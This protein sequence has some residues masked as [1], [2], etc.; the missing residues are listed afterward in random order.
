MA[1]SFMERRKM[2]VV[3]EQPVLEAWRPPARKETLTGAFFW[4]SAFCFVYCARPEDLIPGLSYIPLAKITGF[5]ALVALL[6]SLGKSK[7]GFRDL[8]KEAH[9]LL[10]MTAILY[11]SAVF[12]PVWRGGA[13]LRTLDF[14]KVYI[15]WILTFLAVNEFGR[16]RRLIFI[17]TAS[18]ALICV[19]SIAKGH[20]RPRLDGVLGGIYSN[21][22][23][24]AFAIV[25]SLPFCLAFL[26]A[27]K[28]IP[29]KAAWLFAILSMLVAVFLT[30]SRGGFITLVVAG[31]VCLWHFGVK[32]R[33]FYLVVAAGLLGSVLLVTAGR[34]VIDRFIAI[35]GT[36][37]TQSDNRAYGSYEQRKFLMLKALEGIER[38]PILG[39]G[40]RNFEVYS[41]VWRE[42]HM[43]YLEIAVEGGVPAAILYI[44]FFACGFRSLKRLRRRKDLDPEMALFVGALHSSLV[45]FVVG[46]LFSP[47]AYQF[48][49]YFAVAYASAF[50]AI[51]EEKEPV[52]VAKV[53]TPARRFSGNY[54]N[55]RESGVGPTFR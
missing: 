40:V 28:S 13:L 31:V 11:L 36:V 50:L 41:T 39:V 10:A 53:L 19:V 15:I 20:S 32:G 48:F 37:D 6:A 9:Y 12:S 49:P 44:L 35:S 22:N 47:E 43:T 51:V 55:A 21:P 18:V 24:L 33:R 34:R 14:S 4:L 38:Y 42:V 54:S 27:T 7:R 8:P 52:P 16:L 29:R 17:Q 3:A 23:D 25:L 26:I 1:D 30:A 46:A 5:F 45:G 2:S